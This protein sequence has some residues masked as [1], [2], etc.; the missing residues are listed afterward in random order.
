M[1]LRGSQLSVSC[2]LIFLEW[3]ADIFWKVCLYLGLSQ[4]WKTELAPNIEVTVGRRWVNFHILTHPE[5][6]QCFP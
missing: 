3:R 2:G 6:Q 1:E 4:A 5:L